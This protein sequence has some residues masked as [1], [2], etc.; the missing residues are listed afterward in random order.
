MSEVTRCSHS[1]TDVEARLLSAESYVGCKT[2]QKSLLP[3]ESKMALAAIVVSVACL[4]VVL[5]CCYW[6]MVFGINTSMSAVA[7]AKEEVCLPCMQVTPDPLDESRPPVLSGL[8]V[9]RDDESDE[10]I[11]CARTPSQ[12]AAL[13]KLVNEE[14]I[15]F[16]FDDNLIII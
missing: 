16:K 15:Y 8:D 3:S 2:K 12:F 1:C 6:L 4:L 13:F 9:R 7:A 14:L 11:C 10:E 5:G